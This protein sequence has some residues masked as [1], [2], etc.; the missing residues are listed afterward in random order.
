V[1]TANFEAPFLGS[2]A[3]YAADFYKTRGPLTPIEGVGP[4]PITESVSDVAVIPELNAEQISEVKSL[5][6]EYSEIF[7]V[8]K[9]MDLTNTQWKKNQCKAN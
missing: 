2:A 9:V 5:L 7:N 1:H 3:M 4:T 8:P 6:Q